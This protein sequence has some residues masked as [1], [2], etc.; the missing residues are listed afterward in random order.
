MKNV[1]EFKKK[2]F[3]ETFQFFQILSTHVGVVQKTLSAHSG[4]SEKPIPAWGSV[5]DVEDVPNQR[6]IKLFCRSLMYLTHLISC[7]CSKN[8]L[9]Y[10]FCSW[11]WLSLL[12]F[13][14]CSNQTRSIYRLWKWIS[15][16]I[17][18]DIFNGSIFLAFSNLNISNGSI[19]LA[20]SNLNIFNGSIFLAFFRL[21]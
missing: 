14:F 4:H 2:L 20:S 8:K 18:A 21:S 12:N 15:V 1:F 11:H 13:C 7:T 19:F 5:W 3:N 6:D 10:W 9:W 17:N 16:V